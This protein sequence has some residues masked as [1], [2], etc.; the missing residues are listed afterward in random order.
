[1]DE[2][3]ILKLDEAGLHERFSVII[4]KVERIDDDDPKEESD[5]RIGKLLAEGRLICKR[6]DPIVRERYRDDPAALADWDEIFH[7]CDDLEEE[8]PTDGGPSRVD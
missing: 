4:D 7:S 5:P 2:A 3:D 6:L 1:M 8:V